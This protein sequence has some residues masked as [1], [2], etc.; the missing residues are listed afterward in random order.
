VTGPLR[1]PSPARAVATR[2]LHR[3]AEDEAF[4]T[5]SLDAEIRRASLDARDAALASE[6]VY[7]ALRVVSSLDRAID[8]HLPR[9]PAGVDP[10]TRAALRAATYQVLHLER[11]PPRAAVS[12]AVSI[13]RKKRSEGLARFANAVLRKVAAAR[14]AAPHPPERVDVPDWL[15]AE[16]ASSLGA[17]RAARFLEVR[18]LPPPLGLRV[19]PGFS[20]GEVAE[21]IREARPAAEVHEAP[22]AAQ[23]LL[24]RRAGDPRSL[25]GYE[26]GA[27]VVQELGAQLVGLALGAEPGERIADLCAGH[28]GKTLQLLDV[29]APTGHLTAV[30]LHERKLER[31]G[32]EVHR[33]AIDTGRVAA[34]AIDLTAGAGGLGADFD[35]VLV[36]AP[37]T[38]LGTLHRRPELLLRASSGDPARLAELQLAIL[39][40]AAG[41]VRPGGTLL[42][43]VCSP[44]LAEGLAVAERAEGCVP[45]L[46]RERSPLPGSGLPCDPDGVTRLGPWSDAAGSA[47]VYQVVRWRVL[48][49]KTG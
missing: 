1:G 6:I 22:G 17:E 29:T 37:C 36:D 5:A 25:P 10:L 43:A 24:V 21:R 47:D 46:E 39:R 42:Y 19:R 44:T 32:G 3:V 15:A 7:G 11:V 18:P 13:V 9:G 12:D 31:I 35:R 48:P 33:L 26:A 41:L 2:V 20:R 14:P 40:R 8:A 49:L 16:L 34:R 4:A 38:N 30:D 45:G 28:G 27:F 23:V